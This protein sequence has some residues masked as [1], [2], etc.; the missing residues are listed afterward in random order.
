MIVLTARYQCKPGMGNKVEEALKE[1]IPFVEEEK[2]CVHY[3]VNRAKDNPDEFLLFEQYEDEAAL[4]RHSE[5]PYFKRII[6]D[7][8][9]PLL[10][11]RE[12]TLYT[13]VKA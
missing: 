13:P 7:T 1:M 11:K 4:E 5:T 6:L 2:G 8:V 12:R 9:I 3:F 10:E